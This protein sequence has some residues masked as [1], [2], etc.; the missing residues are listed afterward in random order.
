MCARV[1]TQ[2]EVSTSIGACAFV[3]VDPIFQSPIQQQ[4]NLPIAQPYLRTHKHPRGILH[5][6]HARPRPPTPVAPAQRVCV[7]C[8]WMIRIGWVGIGVCVGTRPSNPWATPPPPKPD[9]PKPPKRT[10]KDLILAAGPAPA[11]SECAHPCCYYRWCLLLLVVMVVVLVLIE[12]RF[13]CCCCV[14]CLA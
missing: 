3:G 10:S 7:V 6:H 5:H 9:Q 13:G 8:A 14:R 12:A 2:R 11:P 4:P 1:Y